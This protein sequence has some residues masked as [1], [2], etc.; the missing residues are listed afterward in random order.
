[1][2]E[3]RLA[4]LLDAPVHFWAVHSEEVE[5][6]ESWWRK[7]TIEEAWFVAYDEG[8]PV[9][10]A[11]GLSDPEAPPVTLDL[12]SMWVTPRD[13]GRGVARALIE[14]IATWAREEGGDVLSLWATSTNDAAFRLYESAGFERTGRSVEHPRDPSL[15]FIEL[16][17]PL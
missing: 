3:L 8:R 5:E 9:G 2:R 14:A 13:R 11:A 16:A 15:R 12:V 4:A 1:M 17:R 7:V 6:P 10:I